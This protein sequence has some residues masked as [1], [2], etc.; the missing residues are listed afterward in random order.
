MTYTYTCANCGEIVEITC[1]ISEK[2][3]REKELFCPSCGR[4]E[5]VR[6]FNAFIARKRE[7]AG[8]SNSGAGSCACLRRG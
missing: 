7:S 4:K 2:E 3:G 8:S 1:S 6:V 5:F